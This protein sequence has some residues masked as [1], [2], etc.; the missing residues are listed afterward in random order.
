MLIALIMQYFPSTYLSSNWKVVPFNHFQLITPRP[1]HLPLATTI[2]DLVLHDFVCLFALKYNWPAT[3]WWFLV[4]NH[5]DLLF[6]YI[7][8]W[9]PQ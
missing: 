6:L 4:Y 7:K 9:S 3:L 1:Y 8:K 2:N 5:S